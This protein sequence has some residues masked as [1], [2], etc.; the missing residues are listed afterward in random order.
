MKIKRVALI[1]GLVIL[2]LCFFSIVSY[3]N[4]GFAI[5]KIRTH[6]AYHKKW[7]VKNIPSETVTSLL[8]Q[9]YY[10]IGRGSQCYVFESEDRSLVLKFFR[11]NR[12]RAPGWTRLFSH[13]QILEDFYRQKK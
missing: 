5:R 3:L 1:V 11:L 12:Y 9:N 8:A 10:Y 7:E 2:P 6:L 4:D 13:P